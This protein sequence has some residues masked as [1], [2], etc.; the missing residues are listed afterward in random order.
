[1]KTLIITAHPD[2]EKS[3]VNNRW[4]QELAA[5][6]DRIQIHELYKEY[7]AWSIDVAKE[8]K[9][10]ETHDHIIF[11][12]PLYWYSYPP[13]LKKW[14]DDVFTHG[15]AY[16]SQGHSLEGKRFGL[17]LSIG[18]KKKNYTHA[19]AIGFTVDELLAPF[20]AS[21]THVGAVMLPY[22]A[23]FG[24]SFQATDADV[25]QSAKDYAAYVLFHY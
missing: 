19:G 22:F 2:L 13:L 21:A 14:L 12:F 17:A 1:M 3:R 6:P 4:N 25:E 24:S 15:W 16:G 23:F 20:K 7:P 9:L 8:Q 5:Y 10:L 18:D 11:Q